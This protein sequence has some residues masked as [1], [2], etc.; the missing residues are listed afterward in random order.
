MYKG[1]AEARAYAQAFLPAAQGL[2]A[3]ADIALL[4][5]FVDLEA[6]NRALEGTTIAFGAQ[7][8]FWEPQG[9]FT[10]EISPLM[11]KELGCAYC[12]VGHSERRR[13]CGETD[14][15]V[16]RKVAALLGQ[17]ITP[18]VCVG[19]SL[20]ENREG[21]TRERVSEQIQV[22]L[23]EFSDAERAVLVIAYEPVWA[24]GT[25][26]ADNPASANETINMIRGAAGGLKEVRIL[27]GGSMNADNVA[28]FCAQP[29]IDGGLIGSASLDPLA[30]V[31]LIT[32]GTQVLDAR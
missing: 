25:G 11:L 13:L 20:E 16:A 26:L 29:D 30:F 17:A 15:Q 7:D 19:E 10:G 3:S 18:I 8:S 9:A 31:R 22:G 27:Y 24:I 12:I 32:N 23:G 5:P 1:P 14:A 28:A 2:I 4:A 21:R 6:L